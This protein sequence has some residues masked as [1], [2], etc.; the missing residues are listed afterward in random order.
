MLYPPFPDGSWHQVYQNVIDPIETLTFV[1]G[2]TQKIKLATGIIDM[3]YQNSLLLAN[4]LVA[5][6]NL[7]KGRLE[8]GLGLGHSKDEFQATGTPFD[9]RGERADEFLQVLEKVW[10]D[11]VVEHNGKYYTI[12]KSVIVQKPF[13]KR[14]PIYLTGFSPKALGRMISSNA[15]GWVGI[16]HLD[17]DGFKAGQAQLQKAAQEQERDPKSVELPVLLF[18]EVTKIDLGEDRNPMNGSI[19]EIVQDIKEFEKLGVNHVNLVFDF[20]T[21][22]QD[23]KARLDYAKQIRKQTLSR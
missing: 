7:S 21:H 23:I 9:N 13:Q 14:I 22:S 17:I 4:R 15:N 19:G 18:P 12:P 6:D 1:A 11:D 2:I 10:H 16:P 5:L 8:L 20:G 3:V